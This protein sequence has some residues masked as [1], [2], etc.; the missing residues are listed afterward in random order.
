VNILWSLTNRIF[1]ASALLVVA[2]MGIAIYRVNVSVASQAEADLRAGLDEATSLVD[3]VSR[4]TFVDFVVKAQLIADLP[5]LQAA[6]AD[7]N[8][9]TAQPVAAEYQQ[10]IGADLFVVMGRGDRVLAR[11]GR[12]QLG[13]PSLVAI[14]AAC[15]AAHD[16]TYFWPF[17]GGLLHVAAIPFEDGL[18]TLIVGTTLDREAATQIK[19]VTNSEIAF[20][21]GHSIVAT[22]LDAGRAAELARQPPAAA[23]FTVPLGDEVFIGRRQSLAGPDEVGA[24]VALVLRSRTEHLRFL[25][26]LHWQIALTGLVA[27]L[28]ATLVGYLVARTVTRPLRALTG[29]MR[30]MAA[31]GDL[32]RTLPALG[33][34]DDEDVRLVATTFHQLTSAL[35][36]FQRES[37]LR[38]RLSSLGRLSTVVAHEIRNPLMI[39]KSTARTLKRHASPDVAGAAT[40]IDEEVGRLNRVVTGV[41]DFAKP[42]QY[43]I[44][45]T[46][47]ADVCRTAVQ[48]AL[49]A[50]ED[51]PIETDLPSRAAPI[52]TDADRLRS[53]LVNV[54]NNA[55]QAVRDRYPAGEAVRP[56]VLVQAVHA[57]GRH[58][59]IAV[60]DRG[61][62]IAADDLP[63]IFDPFFTTRRGG[64]GLGLAISRNIIEGLGGTMIVESE[65]GRGTTVRIDLGDRAPEAAARA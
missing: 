65:T 55:Q 39:I 57:T 10:K 8:P 54:L 4:R 60:I 52:A 12:I 20:V 22:S 21:S 15:R 51:V 2:A 17:P 59:Q 29:A 42:I 64:S 5:R 37:A 33:R 23:I 24:P 38:E 36:R 30:E 53:V 41:L 28:G 16:G 47:L 58:W 18:H 14:L 27:V 3:Q 13:D 31:T 19:T 6:A 35:D 50:A 32:A 26:R 1:L 61:A 48:A 45:N 44:S 43:D 46:D 34:W 7:D 40:S 25:P 63:R 62:G 49:A 9:P 11:A 56:P